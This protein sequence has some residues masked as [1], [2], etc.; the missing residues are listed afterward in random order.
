MAC[1]YGHTSIDSSRCTHIYPAA[2]SE[3]TSCPDHPYT[4]WNHLLRINQVPFITKR[5]KHPLILLHNSLQ[6]LHLRHKCSAPNL[7][8]F[9]LRVLALSYTRCALDDKAPGAR[10]LPPLVTMAAF[11][12]MLRINSQAA[13]HL[14]RVVTSRSVHLVNLS[15]SLPLQ[16]LQL[17]AI[18]LVG[19]QAKKKTQKSTLIH[20]LYLHPK[21]PQL[22]RQGKRLI[23]LLRRHLLATQ[24]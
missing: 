9:P 1:L 23:P 20:W 2:S 8:G 10:L 12:K 11:I 7:L 14:L 21:R 24:T 19:D 6:P 18:L 3:P 17:G 4:A 5:S 16:T 22:S 13:R 15:A